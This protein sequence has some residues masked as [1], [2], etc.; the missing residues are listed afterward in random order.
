MID[1][2]LKTFCCAAECGSFARAAEAMYLSP[3]AVKKRITALEDSLGC[4]LFKRSGSGIT[5]TPAGN[6]YYIGAKKL[7]SDYAFLVRDVQKAA[8]ITSDIVRV[9]ISET[10]TDSFLL[11]DWRKALEPAKDEKL[12]VI[13]YGPSEQDIEKMLHDIGSSLDLAV[14]LYD[15]HIAK[16]FRLQATRTSTSGFSICVPQDHPFYDRA[17]L[18]M[19]DLNGSTVRF[20]PPKRSAVFDALRQEFADKQIDIH[21]ETIERFDILAFDRCTHDHLP[22]ITSGNYASVFPYTHFIP[23]KTDLTISFGIY[24][25]KSP[26]PSILKFI[27]KYR[28]TGAD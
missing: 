4:Q 14:D 17:S 26:S 15:P 22:I 28:L 21:Y 11:S 7:L 2:E 24:H 5:L 20:L 8:G 25:S 9:G 1:E 18:S 6:A 27:Q 10:F 3:N 16:L 12:A 13:T 23:L 19:E